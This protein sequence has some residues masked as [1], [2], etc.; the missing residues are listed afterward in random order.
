MKSRCKYSG[1]YQGIKYDSGWES[2]ENFLAD[3]GKRPAGTSLD[4][5]NVWGDYRKIN[6]RWA[7]VE[8]QANNKRNTRLIR[9]DWRI[10][11]RYGGTLGSVA[12]WARYLR[13][14][15]RSKVWTT[16]R[17]RSVLEVMSINEIVMAVSPC[18]TA[19][20]ELAQQAALEMG[21]MFRGQLE[22]VYLQ[23]A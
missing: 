23:A 21:E 1:N 10:G 13:M 8:T 15:T 2:F 22:A 19:P 11:D 9:Y 5:I 7:T 3:M 20:E 14:L 17:L 16:K 18:W 4:R 12:E 6:C